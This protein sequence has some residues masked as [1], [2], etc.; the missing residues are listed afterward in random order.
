[1]LM[2]RSECLGALAIYSDQNAAFRREEAQLLQNLAADIAYGL[3]TLRTRAEGERLQRELLEIS[4]REQRRIAQDLHDGL[5]Q[6]LIGASF[7]VAGM[8][9]RMAERHDAEADAMK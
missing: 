6:Q 2:W 4:E 3:A 1:P 9:R 7:L 5:C 8:H